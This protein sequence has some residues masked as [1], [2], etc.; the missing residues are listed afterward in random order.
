MPVCFHTACYRASC[1][2]TCHFC[3]DY[4]KEL[5]SP[6][7]LTKY[8]VAKH[9]QEYATKFHLN[10]ILAATIQSSVYS[11]SEKKWTVKF[12]T[13]DGNAT[14]TIISKHL[15]QA[16]GL[17]CGKPYLPPM[18]DEQRYKGLSIHST[19]YRN[20]QILADQGI[21]VGS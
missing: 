13:A 21:K 17:G 15:V 10:T 12:K 18:Q 9:L 5:Q 19:R 3:L 6:H 1:R 11:S 4:A 14:R 7:R 20:A 16:T 2:L 8:D